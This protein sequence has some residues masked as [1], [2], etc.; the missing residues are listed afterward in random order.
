MTLGLLRAAAST[1]GLALA[2]SVKIG[3]DYIDPAFHQAAAGEPCVNY[4]PWAMREELLLANATEAASAGRLL[5]IEAMMGLFDAAADG[6]GSAGD[7]ASALHLPVVFV[8]NCARM[9]HSVAALVRGFA[10]FDENL[11]IAGVVLNNVGS[12]RH[13]RLLRDA[14]AATGMD[15]I[16]VLRR[17]EALR[18]PERHLGL[19]QAG[20]HANLER[21]IERAATSVERGCDLDALTALADS[22][23]IAAS[24]TAVASLPPPGQRVAVACDLAFAFSYEHLLRGWRAAGAELRLFS[25]LADEAPATDSDAV[26]LPGGYPELHAGRIAGNATF[27]SGM[28]RAG[29]DGVPV[30]G[31]C[32]GYMVLGDALVDADGDRHAMLGLLPLTTSFAERQLHLGYRRL[33][34][35]PG[36]FWNMPVTAHEFHYATIVEEG[37]AERLFE[38]EDARGE[39]LPPAGLRRGSVAG[40]FMHLIDRTTG[41]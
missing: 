32:G 31:E 23:G 40:S 9:S 13:E 3:P 11:A 7:L 20:E 15:V 21:F 14:L 25:P 12:D 4:D 30:Y 35:A 28:T 26:Y 24:R 6:S 22:A 10:D 17:N 16:G 8:V 34:P 5:L 39:A 36:F 19:V 18:L 2:A 41:A 1:S 29:R 38:V 27:K 37:D 33:L